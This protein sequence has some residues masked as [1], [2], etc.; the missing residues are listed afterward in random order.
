M[1]PLQT[2]LEDEHL[3]VLADPED[4]FVPG[5]VAPAFDAAQRT[6]LC[7]D[8]VE[9]HR[10]GEEIA[11]PLS[12][13]LIAVPAC[14]PWPDSAGVVALAE[15]VTA[16]FALDRGAALCLAVAVTRRLGRQGLRPA[17]LLD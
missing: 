13:A 4:A 7:R 17:G 5:S 12:R 2:L 15:S 9:D 16:R 3:E 8:L 6:R 14:D 1:N 10:V 11:R